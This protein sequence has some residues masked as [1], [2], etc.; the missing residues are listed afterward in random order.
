MN[1]THLRTLLTIHKHLNYTRAAEE[2]YLSQPAVSRQIQQLEKTVG[3]ELFEQIGKTL[4]LTDAG[5]ALV[6]EA[7]RLLAMH[8]R[9]A[10]RIGAFQRGVAGR[11]RIGA[12]TTPGCYLLP[13]IL[14]RF[15]RDNPEVELQYTVEAS[16][17]IEHKILRNEL[18]VGFV[19][20]PPTDRE[21]VTEEIARDRIVCFARNDHPLASRSRI[22]IKSLANETWILRE[23][24]SAT[25]QL[26]SNWYETA[27]GSFGHTI[28]LRSLEGVRELVASGVGI[29]CV[30]IRAIET[31][32]ETK[33]VSTLRL[34][35]L[36]LSRP[37]L[38]IRHIDKPLTPL[39]ATFLV[40]VRTETSTD[41]EP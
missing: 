5:R 38:M 24:E 1:P 18:D 6:P 14:G 35:G 9:V 29:S 23:K 21:I 15:T 32:L 16:G 31:D 36:N 40:R 28:E 30:S 41:G 39:L 19:G 3:V 4:S 33:R 17:Q 11:L 37:I 27:G 25:R 10:E 2:L 26:F 7:E 22:S 8:A 34:T 20:A 13:P 12:G